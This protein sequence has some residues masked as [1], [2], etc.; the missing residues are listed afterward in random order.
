MYSIPLA[1]DVIMHDAAAMLPLLRKAVG[2]I[3]LSCLLPAKHVQ[4]NDL[5]VQELTWLKQ[6]LSELIN[7]NSS[8]SPQSR[9][10][11]M[12]LTVTVRWASIDLRWTA[13]GVAEAVYLPLRLLTESQMLEVRGFCSGRLHQV[14][15]IA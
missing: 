5:L 14:L 12:L 13:S 6:F 7:F 9:S 11:F 15:S 10:V 4:L 8:A 3:A 1:F 2:S